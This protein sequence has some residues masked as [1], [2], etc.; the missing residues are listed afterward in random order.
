MLR[1]TVMQVS[2][3]KGGLP[4]FA[5]AEAWA[6]PLGLEGDVQ[7]HTAIHGGPRKALLLV[8]DED[9]EWLRGQGF[10][11][12]A[13]SLGEN[14]TVRGIDFRQVREGM[15]FR[16]GGAAIELTTRR[17]PCLQLDPYNAGAE[18]RIQAAVYE[19]DGQ[20]GSDKWARAGFYA[21]VVKTGLIR[22]D[23]RIELIDVQA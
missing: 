18:A 14:L 5:V 9:L 13:G 19:K 15:R 4:K 11:V 23:D 16:A 6:G 1:G 17:Q 21:A 8:S 7:A 10:P 22:V 12:R 3:S 20:P 2:V